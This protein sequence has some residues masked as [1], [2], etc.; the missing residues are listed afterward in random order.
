[1]ALAPQTT[2][3]LVT[4]AALVLLGILNFMGIR[5]SARVS[6][7]FA[8]LAAIGQLL[9]VIAVVVS[10]G[11]GGTIHSFAA[12]GHASKMTPVLAVT[13]FAAAFLAFS[14][15]ESIAQISP[16]M[17]SP[18]NRIAARAMLWVVITIAITSPLLTF[19]S[20]TLVPET[21]DPNKLGQLISILGTQVSGPQLGLFVAVTASLLLVFASNTAIIGAY[22]VFVALA[23]MGFL[24]RLL[25]RRNKWRRT[26]HLAILFAIVI[27]I[28]LVVATKGS[29]TILGDL[30]A[31]GL[32]GAF[33]LTC[34]GL[35]VVRRHEGWAKGTLKQRALFG[36]GI[37][38][39]VAVSVAWVTNLINKPLATAFGG[40]LT[41]FGLGVGFATYRWSRRARPTVFPL[42]FQPERA[43]A[44]IADAL[45]RRPAE[46]LVLLP[47][48]PEMA[49]ALL[50]E[51]SRAAGGR[52][53]LF[54][55]RA[56]KPLLDTTD[57]LEVNDPYLRD[58]TAQDAFARAESRTRN[59]IPDRRYIYVPG[60]L[61]PDVVREIWREIRPKETLVVDGEQ[62]SLPPVALDRVRRRNVD[63]TV[64]LH[65]VTGKLRLASL[66]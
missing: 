45:R 62:D 27:P 56:E 2:T 42:P 31:F 30:Y 4:V 3:I 37:F 64:V 26:P 43:S 12:I 39:T 35:D 32:L 10:L 61:Q 38:T 16:A 66:P 51:A 36:V 25:E 54:L 48:D 55:Y 58:Y 20:T 5:E 9:V 19:W 33:V 44:S 22:H 7:L 57:L 11:I 53:A 13:G 40:G 49:E 46:I 59:T 50:Q 63:G 60:N 41:L 18:R 34:L 14:G 52:Q 23:R 1:T 15:L 6:A 17:R 28:I 24:P 29:A 21:T 8:I 47:H 65:L